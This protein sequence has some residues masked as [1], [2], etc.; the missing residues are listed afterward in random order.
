MNR[1]D[2]IG[3]AIGALVAALLLPFED[4]ATWC[5]RWLSEP[6]R[7]SGLRVDQAWLDAF[8]GVD[9]PARF[10]PRLPTRL[11]FKRMIERSFPGIEVTV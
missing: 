5:R 9:R 3:A 11:V 10:G 4:F 1:R 7:L 2:F 6:T 8:R